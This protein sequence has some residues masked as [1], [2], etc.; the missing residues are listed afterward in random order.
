MLLLKSGSCFP[1]SDGGSKIRK[2][3]LERESKKGK[4][5]KKILHPP[6]TTSCKTSTQQFQFIIIAVSPEIGRNFACCSITADS[7]WTP[8][9][10]PTK[11]PPRLGSPIFGESNSSVTIL[12]D[13]LKIP[14]ESSRSRDR[15]WPAEQFRTRDLLLLLR[16]FFLPRKKKVKR[17][18]AGGRRRGDRDRFWTGQQPRIRENNTRYRVER[19]L[20][21][22]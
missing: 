2:H 22:S 7:P 3:F 14:L 6:R 17:S 16:V 5:K 1:L 18:A 20:A 11:F 15:C 12:M 10:E 4:K 21:T 19:K 13:Q 9:T 8:S